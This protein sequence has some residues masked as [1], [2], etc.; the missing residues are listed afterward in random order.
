[1]EVK[2]ELWPRPAAYSADATWRVLY[3]L[4][5]LGLAARMPP[6]L[7]LRAQYEAFC[8]A[9]AGGLVPF[10]QLVI[11]PGAYCF[12]SG[13]RIIAWTPDDSHARRVV[14]MSF[15]DLLMR[16]ILELEARKTMMLAQSDERA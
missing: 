10:L 16:E 4:K 7:D 13:Q 14:P 3:G 1:M 12:D 11:A 8:D 9:G 5:V 15:F 6:W 2:E